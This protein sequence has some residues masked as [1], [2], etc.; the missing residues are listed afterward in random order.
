MDYADATLVSLAEE[1]GT[2]EV[3]TLDRSGFAAYRWHGRRPF[4]VRP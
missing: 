2:P 4:H 1:L 3:F